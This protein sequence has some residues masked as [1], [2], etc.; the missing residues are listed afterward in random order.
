MKKLALG[1]CA[2]FGMGIMILSYASPDNAATKVTAQYAYTTGNNS[3]P[4]NIIV[5]EVTENGALTA[6][7]NNP[8]EEIYFVTDIDFNTVNNTTYAY[9][10]RNVSDG[11]S[12][13]KFCTVNTST[14]FLESCETVPGTKLNN[15]M[16]VTVRTAEDQ[17]TYAYMTA[18]YNPNIIR[19][20]LANGKITENDCKTLA[21]T[22]P[23]FAYNLSFQEFNDQAYVYV[24]SRGGNNVTRCEVDN[25]GDLV[26]DTCI[27]M[28]ITYY[29]PYNIEFVSV[30]AQVFSYVTSDTYPSIIKCE[31]DTTT[32][33]F[34]AD[35]CGSI[36]GTSSTWGITANTAANG[37]TYYYLASSP[38]NSNNFIRQCSPI[39]DTCVNLGLFNPAIRSIRF[40]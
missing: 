11:I 31:V 22:F 35:T 10:A 33:L 28:G 5:C 20:N 1:I 7:Q 40:R 15:T 12:P 36:S 25:T 24:T 39:D 17:Q 32:G 6:C 29:Y 9:L 23:S 21:A 18:R 14:A 16:S 26:S 34:L 8:P 38:T 2:A 37:E 27:N 13:M 3:G 4:Q 30:G 19:C